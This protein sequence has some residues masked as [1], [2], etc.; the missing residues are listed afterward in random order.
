MG[1][2]HQGSGLKGAGPPLKK[3]NMTKVFIDGSSGTTGLRI[4]ERLKERDDLELIVL[5]EEKRKDKK[6]VQEAFK[7]ADFAFLCLPDDASE[8]AF[9]MAKNM[10]V[11]L[12]DTSTRHRTD[13]GWAYG[14]AEL[15]DLRGIIRNSRL[16][17]NPGCHASGFLALVRPL[18]EYGLISADTHLVCTS[19]TGYSGGGKNMIHEYESGERSYLLDAPRLYG[20]TQEH[21]HLKEMVTISGLN[22]APAFLPVVADFYAGMET[23]VPL[24]KKDILKGSMEEIRDCYREYYQKSGHV[25]YFEETIDDGG[26][27]ASGKLAGYDDMIIS[28]SGNEERILLVAL[29]DNLGKGACGAAIQ[30]LNIMMGVDEEK[31]LKLSSV[32]SL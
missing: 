16:V 1:T 30:N 17:A 7:E 15:S 21:K 8:E 9:E 23:I 26:F 3:K 2:S 11:R 4:R 13:P 25:V 31:G 14:F 28:V 5:G 10:E 12:I 6:S 20:L 24:F 29:F 18:V 32:P 22:Y 27:I 19:L